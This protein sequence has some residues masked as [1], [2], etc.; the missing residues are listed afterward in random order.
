MMDY[1]LIS[2]LIYIIFIINY[3]Y[4]LLLFYLYIQ[5]LNPFIMNLLLY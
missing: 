5:I 1:V 3:S 4:I 2:L